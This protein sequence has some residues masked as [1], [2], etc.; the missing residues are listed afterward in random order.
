[1]A[2]N[3]LMMRIQLLVDGGKSSAELGRVAKSL[4]D[5]T[6]Q[7]D[8]VQKTQLDLKDQVGQLNDLKTALR[9]VNAKNFVQSLSEVN[10]AFN[11]L[12]LDPK[13]I[14]ALRTA[15][16]DLGTKKAALE[17]KDYTGQLKN[18]AEQ[19]KEA[20]RYKLTSALDTPT[21]AVARM[22]ALK[23][24]AKQYTDQI[25]NTV[26]AL[27]LER[28]AVIDLNRQ[29]QNSANLYAIKRTNDD[30]NA[31]SLEALKNQLTSSERQLLQWNR[32]LV[33]EK[34]LLGLTK[35]ALKEVRS[36]SSQLGKSKLLDFGLQSSDIANIQKF[37][38]SI[39]KS[40]DVGAIQKARDEIF[41]LKDQIKEQQ[42]LVKDTKSLVPLATGD[43]EK[44]KM[45]LRG[46]TIEIAN[47]NKAIAEQKEL[48][49]KALLLTD[50]E[51]TKGQALRTA[52]EQT[53]QSISGYANSAKQAK[54]FINELNQALR[55]IKFDASQAKGLLLPD[56]AGQ[57]SQLNEIRHQL[58]S[59]DLTKLKDLRE[60]IRLVQQGGRDGTFTLINEG[61]RD[62]I[63]KVTQDV[64]DLRQ[65][66]RI[67]GQP[68][69]INFKDSSG[70]VRNLISDVTTLKNNILQLKQFSAGEGLIK[71]FQ[72]DTSQKQKLNE[73]LVA[74][75][76]LNDLYGLTASSLGTI[77]EAY[78]QYN[79][80]AKKGDTAARANIDSAI[81]SYNNLNKLLGANKGEGLQFGLKT[82]TA[83]KRISDL[84]TKIKS[85]SG[86]S[87][88]D[89]ARINAELSN[90]KPIA[91]DQSITLSG[92]NQIQKAIRDIKAE[93]QAFKLENI[94]P[95]D[96]RTKVYSNEMSALKLLREETKAY[97]DEVKKEV[98]DPKE[99]GR[100]QA[101]IAAITSELNSLVKAGKFSEQVFKNIFSGNE[102]GNVN[103]DKLK[104][105]LDLLQRQTVF[106]KLNASILGQQNAERSKE[107]ANLV[108]QEVIGKNN[109]ANIKAQLEQVN[110]LVTEERAR[111]KAASENIKSNQLNTKLGE[112]NALKSINEELK[113]VLKTEQQRRQGL[114]ETAKLLLDQGKSR[115]LDFTAQIPGLQQLVNLNRDAK[116]QAEGTVKALKEAVQSRKDEITQLEQQ[117]KIN[118]EVYQR[119]I[120]Q[121]TANRAATESIKVANEAEKQ[122]LLL[123]RD[124]QQGKIDLDTATAKLKLGELESLLASTTTKFNELRKAAQQSAK[125]AENLAKSD[126]SG[127]QQSIQ[128]MD[129][130]I[131]KIKERVKTD[132]Q[133]IKAYAQG[134]KEYEKGLKAEITAANQRIAS[135]QLNK[136]QYEEERK[137][138]NNLIKERQQYSKDY[139]QTLRDAQATKQLELKT[140]R[141]AI[142]LLEQQAK[143]LQGVA[144]AQLDAEVAQR[145]RSL[146]QQG[147]VESQVKKQIQETESLTRAELNRLAALEKIAHQTHSLS[148]IFRRL[149]GSASV[150]PA[151]QATQKLMTNVTEQ[152]KK[153]GEESAAAKQKLATMGATSD[154]PN[155]KR[156]IQDVQGQ[157]KDLRSIGLN[158]LAPSQ[159]AEFVNLRDTLKNLREQQKLLTQIAQIDTR[160]QA[161][162][163]ESKK[164][165][166]QLKGLRAYASEM[167]RVSRF[168]QGFGF[169]LS[170]EM[171]GMSAFQTVT[172]AIHRMGSAFIEANSKAETLIRGLD[173]VFGKG[174]GDIQY[175]KL[176]ALANKYGLGL[177]DLSRNYLQLNASAKGTTLEGAESEKI[178]T[179]LSAA[180]AVLGADTIST[181]RA[182][183]A[184]SQMISKGQ[185][186][187]EELKGQL[188]ESLPGAVQLFARSMGKTTQEFLAMVKAGNVG[189]NELIPFFKL[190]EQE[191]GNA[192]TASTT[193]EQATNRLGNAL[194]LLLKNVGDT[195]LW[196]SLVSL[197]DATAKE[198]QKA[199][200]Y[201]T[202]FG[203]SI[204]SVINE[205]RSTYNVID[206]KFRLS[207]ANTNDQTG[208]LE[209]VIAEFNAFDKKFTEWW[210]AV[211]QKANSGLREFFASTIGETKKLTLLT[212]EQFDALN[213]ITDPTAYM[214]EYKQYVDQVLAENARIAQ[215]EQE[216][217]NERRRYA[218]ASIDANMSY[219]NRMR[220]EEDQL[221]KT[222]T[223]YLGLDTEKS[224]TEKFNLTK[225]VIKDI[226]DQLNIQQKAYLAINAIQSK[227]TSNEIKRLQAITGID[228]ET[229]SKLIIDEVKNTIALKNAQD[230]LNR[231]KLIENVIDSKTDPAQAAEVKK[232]AINQLDHSL[233]LARTANNAELVAGI[234]REI[235]RLTREINETGKSNTSMQLLSG[236][237]AE[238]RTYVE[239]TN[240]ELKLSATNTS[241]VV[242]E[243]S[244][245]LSLT[246]Q[247]NRLLKL[248]QGI[249]SSGAVADDT[250]RWD[251]AKANIDT[252]K[253]TERA[254][255]TKYL[256]IANEALA[257]S[258]ET[259]AKIKV[260]QDPIA[261]E[262]LKGEFQA[263]TEYAGKF[264]SSIDKAGRRAR[265][266]NDALAAI[267]IDGRKFIQGLNEQIVADE[268]AK[269]E[270][271]LKQFEKYINEDKTI[272]F[273]L[274]FEDIDK[275][276][277]RQVE[278][279]NSTVEQIKNAPDAASK[280]AL[281]ATKKEI[282]DRISVLTATREELVKSY[283]GQ[284]A[285]GNATPIDLKFNLPKDASAAVEAYRKTLE[286]Q[287]RN[288]DIT[289]MIR[290]EQATQE[291]DKAISA[292][293]T[294]ADEKP[295][296]FKTEIQSG[297]AVASNNKI[298][299]P[300]PDTS[301]W[302]EAVIAVSDFFFASA[303]ASPLVNSIGVVDASLSKATTEAYRTQEAV[304]GINNAID[305][306]LIKASFGD[307]LLGLANQWNQ[308]LDLLKQ[309]QITPSVNVQPAQS[310]L[311]TLQAKIDSIKQK[312]SELQSQQPQGIVAG[313]FS[314]EVN[315]REQAIAKLRLE[316]VNL[317]NQLA[318]VNTTAQT[319]IAPKVDTTS[320][321]QAK[322]AITTIRQEISDSK[323]GEPIVVKAETQQAIT[324]IQK[325]IKERDNYRQSAM[326][327]PT[328]NPSNYYNT[329]EAMNQRI[330]ASMN[331]NSVAVAQFVKNYSMDFVRGNEIVVNSFK[332]IKSRGIDALKKDYQNLK[333]DN[334][335]IKVD[336][337]G[338][339]R[340]VQRLQITGQN[341]LDKPFVMENFQV[342]AKTW[343]DIVSE[344]NRFMRNSELILQCKLDPAFV[345]DV[346]S[347]VKVKPT[348]DNPQLAYQEMQAKLK[349][350]NPITVTINAQGM[351]GEIQS[352]LARL[353][354]SGATNIQV[355]LDEKT[356]QLV[357]TADTS[358]ATSE[359]DS[360][361]RK[362][363]SST[364]VLKVNIK[365]NDPGRPST[366]KIGGFARGGQIPGGYS[367]R[368]SFLAMLAPGEFVIP[369]NIVKQYGPG[370]FNSLIK[371][372]SAPSVRDNIRVPHFANGGMAGAATTVN[373]NFGSAGKFS[374]SGSRDQVN[375]V[376]KALSQ[377]A[378]TL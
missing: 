182:F 264:G 336:E 164:L 138:I 160:T 377:I 249:E 170:A 54:Q 202:V 98:S 1:M 149:N 110:Q 125:E 341:A 148:S 310:E 88:A 141:D 209:T 272:N 121:L 7:L 200:N 41:S 246:E 105:Q 73:Q 369:S 68:N 234:M 282:T 237:T 154:L 25:K 87:V 137:N 35:D 122:R 284:V 222:R 102:V 115:A 113:S 166:E 196:T 168:M 268:L 362:I 319:P 135:G 177:Q 206:I 195:G 227:T 94:A 302:R 321:D 130:M 348:F 58:K 139:V 342:K 90:I 211:P 51:V 376:T 76:K 271:Q 326:E 303:Q 186:Y 60:Q 178:F 142:K 327:S 42:Q 9:G 340:Q 250:D 212:K 298:E 23:I 279:Y 343:D 199:A 318:S 270:A 30:P 274:G 273:K 57:L 275:D 278:L 99:L 18:V 114:R 292:M 173:A 31:K 197:I 347:E 150:E 361:I 367:M 232:L 304:K 123:A 267:K 37:L 360:V 296:V 351:I 215:A 291:V 49:A 39:G 242:R 24:Q 290:P 324:N 218:N 10:A 108:R 29:I 167:G 184:V 8:K 12:S 226:T 175:E 144:K 224:T 219:Y 70:Q 17:A 13:N 118:A 45:L 65:Q 228:K 253:L 330:R 74:Q 11:K 158:N 378:R 358:N 240:A 133:A 207:T 112:L 128:T 373:F 82:D 322:T 201:A 300:N 116:T 295:I 213:G 132:A 48:R 192:A 66:L 180:M 216:L 190:I 313:G 3:D 107:L 214:G 375:G 328:F 357:V 305:A 131:A 243:M 286:G 145:K 176:T 79:D 191:Y 85:L 15:F 109:I 93:Q 346:S 33:N 235:V 337:Q 365:Y 198:L 312:L 19:I 236:V 163:A 374:L 157:L 52:N 50:Q 263:Y 241:A 220:E 189:L 101:N 294:K 258:Q 81:K 259:L 104:E 84:E 233:T 169:N 183:R 97:N 205:I 21:S 331:D 59:I 134:V 329:L 4:A 161:G 27:R 55:A 255:A 126:V 325:L 287:L 2:V 266:F 269:V 127:R 187:A 155:I 185:V 345:N 63:R 62:S 276:L 26:D 111:A 140:E 193:Y 61:R 210:L 297:N 143:A 368:D 38:G 251:A 301:L 306:N 22:T 349:A 261:I 124:Q 323:I 146:A 265:E 69:L 320:V 103:T 223:S 40:I 179:S 47:Q 372:Q 289:T 78:N 36:E 366:G 86:S 28:L 299:L 231:A 339:Q 371:G 245:V 46:N 317:Q 119:K 354:E 83:I 129:Q 277:N 20:S 260:E 75:K 92:L 80:V 293:Q 32:A 238:V 6:R 285:A 244:N 89:I 221:F 188:A 67:E 100:R 44:T 147:G 281:E 344:G 64:R 95:L 352:E 315:Q 152:L 311:Q 136:A 307:G 120:D 77:K 106:G 72:D 359:V 247:R 151:I 314:E 364:A 172:S 356:G 14:D 16:A 5:F 208:L 288:I 91:I 181:Q 174:Q 355:T 230:A 239:Q 204:K 262:Q 71:V 363:E 252:K 370:Y 257:K 56:Q 280:K 165:N 171:L 96:A 254:K 308:F 248:Q 350:E 217:V 34:N 256:Q 117:K 335:N 332:V 159:G 156:Q 43:L 203:E 53:A 153:L 283:Q 309:N 338:F 353:K 316:L 334:V 194:L 333:L 162:Q 229:N 225:S